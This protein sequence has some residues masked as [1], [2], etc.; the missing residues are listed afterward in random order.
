MAIAQKKYGKTHSG[1]DITMFTLKNNNNMEVSIINYGGT[2]TS[3][4]VPDKNN[5]LDDVVLGYD[6]LSGYESGTKFFGATVGR[7]ANRIENAKFIIN[8]IEYILNKNDGENNLHG[9]IKGFNTAI[10]SLENIDNENNILK[11]SYLSE[12]GEEGFPGN[13]KV[14]VTYSL[15]DDNALRIDYNGISDKDTLVNLTNHSYFNLNGHTADTIYDHKLLINSNKFTPNDTHSIPTGEIKNVENTPMDFSDFK[16]IGK[17]IDAD[18][19]QIRRGAGY[20]HNWLLNSNGNLN[21]LACKAISEKSGRT[22]EIY[23]TKPGVQFYSANFLDSSDIGKNN[24]AY[25][26]RCAFCLETQYVPN[27][28]NNAKFSSPV[29][30]ANSEYKHTTIYKFSTI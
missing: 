28:I 20:D 12:D 13:L 26:R 17:D 9:G 5:N 18:D 27:A 30:K 4:I 3:L 24:T 23:T 11:L 2:I 19:E 25:K 22:L 7:C 6:S 29:L 14:T 21:E 10:W 15:S 1:K 8:D 16:L